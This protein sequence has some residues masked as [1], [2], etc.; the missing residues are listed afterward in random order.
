MALWLYDRII[1]YGRVRVS[2]GTG[3]GAGFE[4]KLAQGKLEEQFCPIRKCASLSNVI[5]M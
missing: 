5:A 3:G 2:A 1:I 4:E